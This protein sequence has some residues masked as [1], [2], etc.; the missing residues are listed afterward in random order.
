[1]FF[2]RDKYLIQLIVAK[3]NSFPKVITDNKS[4]PLYIPYTNYNINIH[5][6]SG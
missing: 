4:I 5:K 1:M 2:W 3:E 6:E